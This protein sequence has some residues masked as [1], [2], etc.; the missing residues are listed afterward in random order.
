MARRL[1]FCRLACGYGNLRGAGRLARHHAQDA[2]ATV[3]VNLRRSASVFYLLMFCPG[4]GSEERQASQYCRACGTDLRAVRITLERPDSI[5][6]SAVTAREEIG[7]AVAEQIRRVQDAG[8]LKRVTD[9]VLPQIEKFLE[10]P[11][12]KRQ[13][14]VRAGVITA[15]SGLGF[16]IFMTLMSAFI[17]DA[18]PL[19]G[20][21]GLGVAGFLV[22][23]GLIINAVFFTGIR[24]E[25]AD[26]AGE[27]D[28]QK[29]VDAGYVPPQLKAQTTSNLGQ[30]P[31]SV[32][33]NT[34]LH[35][36]SDR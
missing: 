6:A 5:T 19:V 11:A 1:I 12:E 24:K 13:R 15:A 10:S 27:A 35:L 29:L 23:I 22:G 4:C 7:R 30:T 3:F 17:G 20:V 16:A 34:T 33:E 31:T 9:H 25:I 36:K 18:D 32:T 26:R 28:E 8:E 2:R 14:R 21:A